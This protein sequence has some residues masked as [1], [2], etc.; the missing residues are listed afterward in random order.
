M[1]KVYDAKLTPNEFAKYVV[2]GDGCDAACYWDERHEDV[3][4]GCTER[5][6][7]AINEAI[8]KQVDRVEKLLGSREIHRKVFG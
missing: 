4:N 6:R 7:I 3:Y 5:E 8:N 1:I 2:G